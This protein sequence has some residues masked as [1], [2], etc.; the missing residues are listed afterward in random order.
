MLLELGPLEGTT[1]DATDLWAAMD[2]QSHTAMKIPGK[3]R[4]GR[5]VVVG[6]D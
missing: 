3:R 5:R 6:W 1:W 4:G 2:T